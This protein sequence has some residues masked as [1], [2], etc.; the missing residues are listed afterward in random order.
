MH[1]RVIRGPSPRFELVETP[2]EIKAILKKAERKLR[3]GDALK[4]SKRGA[5]R[6]LR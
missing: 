3:H 2:T 6:E 5:R 1:Q 4:K